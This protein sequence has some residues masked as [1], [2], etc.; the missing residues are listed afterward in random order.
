M[1]TFVL[2]IVTAVFGALFVAPASGS[3][4]AAAPPVSHR[5]DSSDAAQRQVIAYWTADRMRSAVAGDRLVAGRAAPGPQEPQAGEPTR[6][7]SQKATASTSGYTGGVYSGGGAV[8]NTTGKVFFTEKGFNYVCSGS[9]VAAGNKSLVLTAGHCVNEG[10]GA[11][12]TNFMFVPAYHNGVAPYGV[13]TS[14][15]LTT[16]SQ[17][18]TAG[19]LNHDIGLAVVNLVG[20]KPL[21]DVVGA[22]GIAFNQPRGRVMASFGYPQAAPYDGTTLDWCW[23][24][25]VKD[26]YGAL[27]QGLK[28]NLTGGASGGPWYLGFATA[29]GLGTT[30]SV[31]SY[32]YTGGPYKGYMFGPYFGSVE[33]AAYAAAAAS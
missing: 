15:R 25:A 5:V 18:A 33:Q 19:D 23:G 29:T 22:Q 4:A 14:S 24:T 7:A 10:P 27:D 30:N 9:S 12:V 2:T 31:N 20:G 32:K 28:C 3:D 11:F 21:A 16:T 8:V 17:W 26:P 1:R 6:V 13:W